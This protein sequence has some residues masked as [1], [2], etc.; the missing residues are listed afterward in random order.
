MMRAI[1]LSFLGLV[2]VLA[3]AGLVWCGIIL[4]RQRQ[5]RHACLTWQ[6]IERLERE[7]PL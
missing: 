3:S 5:R 6:E 4:H 1:L 2:F 7:N